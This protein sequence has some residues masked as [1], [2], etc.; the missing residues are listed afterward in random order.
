M[1][2]A[3][4][5]YQRLIRSFATWAAVIEDF[6]ARRYGS[7]A[8]AKI[9]EAASLDAAAQVNRVSA[10]ADPAGDVGTAA[11]L[12]AVDADD[13]ELALRA[14]DRLVRGAR[15]RY[16]AHRDRVSMQLSAIYRWHGDRPP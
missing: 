4:R 8:V 12:D 1:L 6:L 13:R 10:A 16:D 14:F 15:R 11:V 9:A 7:Q 2:S 5:G 3:V